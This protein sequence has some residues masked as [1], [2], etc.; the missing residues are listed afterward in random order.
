MDWVARREPK[1]RLRQAS[2]AHD[3]YKVNIENIKGM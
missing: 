2:I 1:L 3:K